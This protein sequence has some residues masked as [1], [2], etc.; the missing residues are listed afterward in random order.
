MEKKDV[1]GEVQR[2]RERFGAVA[3]EMKEF[4]HTDGVGTGK[5]KGGKK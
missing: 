3:E 1:A 5:G 2:L 4:E